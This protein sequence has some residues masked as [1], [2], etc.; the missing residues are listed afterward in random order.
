MFIIRAL[1]NVIAADGVLPVNYTCSLFCYENKNLL[2]IGL[3][4]L[5]LIVIIISL[6]TIYRCQTL[7]N[8]TTDR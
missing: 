6:L 1:Q 2:L 8:H 7:L 4:R 3:V 5:S